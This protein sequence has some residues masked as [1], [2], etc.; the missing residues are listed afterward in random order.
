MALWALYRLRPAARGRHAGAPAGQE[1]VFEQWPTG[2]LVV[3]P[4]S[5]QILAANPAALRSLGYSLEEIRALRFADIFTVEGLDGEALVGKLGDATMR[6]SLEMIQRC[7]DGSQAKAEGRSNRM[8]WNGDEALG[9]AVTDVTVRR[10]A[11]THLL[12]RHQH[13]AHLAHHDQLTGLPTRLYLQAHL[14][15]AI[16]QARKGGN[17][18]A[19]LFL[20]L[21]RFKHVNDSRGH[22]T[23]DKLLKAV[24]QRI[25]ST[26]RREDRV[27]RMGGGEFVV[28][29]KNL[30]NT[31]KVDD[32]W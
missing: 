27:V 23:G 9:V 1:S 11:E 8:T 21:D 13:L 7:K 14:P 18:L 30:K 32:H 19:V 29:M 4:D 3:K 28:G 25:R 6:A 31:E 10:V 12:E 2:A 20:D 17:V 15:G 22:E 16:E 24:D 26:V 5:L